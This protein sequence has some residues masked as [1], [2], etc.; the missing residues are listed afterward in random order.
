MASGQFIY[1]YKNLEGKSKVGSLD[2]W[3][4]KE[5]FKEATKTDPLPQKM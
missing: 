4:R 2:Y 3:F 1:P 5:K